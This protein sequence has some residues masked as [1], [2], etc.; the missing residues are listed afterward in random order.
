MAVW[1]RGESAME[2]GG[3][4]KVWGRVGGWTSKLNKGV[5]GCG[6]WRGNHMG[7]ED[8]SKNIQFVVG[9]GNRVRFW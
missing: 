9:L 1:E 3:S 8:F 5:H 6:L 2:E 7:W 4:F